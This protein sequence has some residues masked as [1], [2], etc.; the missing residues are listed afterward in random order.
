MKFRSI[1]K[2]FK[3]IEIGP[4]LKGKP[5][6]LEHTFYVK[7]IMGTYKG[8][9]DALSSKTAKPKWEISYKKPKDVN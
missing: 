4:L 5:F 2:P 1:V 7:D 3:D 9:G 8:I 6:E